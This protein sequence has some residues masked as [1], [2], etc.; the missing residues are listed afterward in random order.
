MRPSIYLSCLLLCACNALPN[1]YPASEKT[2]PPTITQRPVPMADPPQTH[3]L[4]NTHTLR[5][6]L[7][8]QALSPEDLDRLKS[9]RLTFALTAEEKDGPPP[10]PIAISEDKMLDEITLPRPP[11]PLFALQVSGQLNDT[12]VFENIPS[13]KAFSIALETYVLLKETPS[14]GGSPSLKVLSGTLK[15]KGLSLDQTLS[16]SL[17]SYEYQDLGVIEKTEV[18]GQITDAQGAPL[19]GVSVQLKAYQRDADPCYQEVF[20]G[21]TDSEGQYSIYGLYA[22]IDYTLT[23]EKNGLRSEKVLNLKS[24]KQGDPDANRHDISLAGN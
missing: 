10:E 11:Q 18:H 6:T 9:Q 3:S 17:S 1:N 5:I 23:A 8:T 22:G 24:N 14:C 2:S 7:D 12:F 21:E 19:A 13:Q 16:L 4:E 20:S 15:S